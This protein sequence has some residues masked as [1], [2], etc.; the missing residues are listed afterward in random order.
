MHTTAEGEDLW[1]SGDEPNR[2]VNLVFANANRDDWQK[3]TS[4]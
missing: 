1:A 3:I 4:P 2:P